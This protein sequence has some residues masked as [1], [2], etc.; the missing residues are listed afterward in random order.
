MNTAF[1]CSS[2]PALSNT[3]LLG[4]QCVRIAGCS[5]VSSDGLCYSCASGYFLKDG[6]C[7]ACHASC[8]TC[9]DSTFCASCNVGYYNATNSNYGTCAQCSVG[10]QTCTSLTACTLCGTGFRLSTGLCVACGLNCQ[11]CTNSAC[12][13][14]AIGYALIGGSCVSCT[15]A[16][17]GGSAG[18]TACSVTTGSIIC[19]QCSSSFYLSLTGACVSCPSAYPNSVLCTLSRPLQCIND[20]VPV[21]A[22]RYY[23]IS[24]QCIANTN[25]CKVM[26]NIYGQCS[27]CYF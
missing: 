26:A 24:N 27:S 14:C 4:G 6:T 21:L 8:T 12:T 3:Y 23:L 5:S 15:T 20:F 9:T 18:C 7:I 11:Q 1:V 16:A 22:S 2:C 10:C 17:N 19:S 25:R 13:S